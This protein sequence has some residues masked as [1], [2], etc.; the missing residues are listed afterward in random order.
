[1][2]IKI[3]LLFIIISLLTGCINGGGGSIGTVNNS[4]DYR[5][6]L[7]AAWDVFNNSDYE[8][9]LIDFNSVRNKSFREVDRDE[10][11][12]GMGWSYL[13][14]NDFDNALKWFLK[15]NKGYAELL[16][17][18]I[19]IYILTNDIE[20]YK[21]AYIYVNS[22]GLISLNAPVELST[23]MEIS[24]IYCNALAG[25]VLYYNGKDKE[26]FRHLEKVKNSSEYE[27][28]YRLQQIYQ[29]IM[30]NYH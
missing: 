18:K 28:D 21:E 6:S 8:Q 4:E 19:S 26:A 14:M 30:T 11:R 17:G 10:A 3:F 1:M 22:S 29:G 27:F 20:K 2:K 15:V 13:K 9:S 23:K 7:D 5:D 16:I 25:I 12:L 24:R